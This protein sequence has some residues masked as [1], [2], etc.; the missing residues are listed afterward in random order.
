MRRLDWAKIIR[1]VDEEALSY[2]EIG[3]RM[4]KRRATIRNTYVH[5]KS[6]GWTAKGP[7]GIKYRSLEG[8]RR[9]VLISSDGKFVKEFS[10]HWEAKRFAKQHKILGYVTRALGIFEDT[11]T[12]VKRPKG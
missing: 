12:D 4:G 7:P 10:T 3:R 11:S 5:S 6:Q 1:L 2:A 9:Y 8:E